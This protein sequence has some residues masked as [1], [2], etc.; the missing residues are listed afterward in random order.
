MWKEYLRNATAKCWIPALICALGKVASKEKKLR[1]AW[2]SF[3]I[4]N[5]IKLRCYEGTKPAE[6]PEQ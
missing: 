5:E 4:S 3:L 1:R 6:L 2:N